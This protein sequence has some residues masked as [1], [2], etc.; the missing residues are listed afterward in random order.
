MRSVGVT[1]EAQVPCP[2]GRGLQRWEMGNGRLVLRE[3]TSKNFFLPSRLPVGCRFR[4]N[5]KMEQRGGTLRAAERCVRE[6]LKGQRMRS[7][8]LLCFD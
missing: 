1:A 7:T 6:D 3:E 2:C 8:G 4:E 5:S